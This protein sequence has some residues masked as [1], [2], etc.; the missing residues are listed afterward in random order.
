LPQESL[1]GV[2]E[3]LFGAI[4]E[5]AR[6]DPEFAQRLSSAIE[7]L[8]AAETE[9]P[10]NPA[11]L[12]PAAIYEQGWESM[13]RER[14]QP[15]SIEQLK[16]IVHQFELDETGRALRW[17]DRERLVELIVKVVSRLDTR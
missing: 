13:L 10:R 11:L 4:L 9:P 14:L 2:L 17:S 8:V 6:R 16:D 1:I 3:R 7:P 5:Q 15:L 12:D